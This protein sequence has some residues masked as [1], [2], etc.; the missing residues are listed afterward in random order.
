MPIQLQP[1]SLYASFD[2]FPSAKGAA[3]HIARMAE[4]L[5]RT[6]DGG[7][8]Y[9]LGGDDLPLYQREGNVEI[10]RYARS[11]PNFLE[12]TI[13]FADRLRLLLEE[14][15]DN[16]ALCHVRDPW[17][18]VPVLER[19]GRGYRT[20]YEVNGLPSIELP[21]TYPG[22]SART[23]AKIRAAEEFCWS[24]ADAIITPSVTIAE[25]LI[26]LGAPAGAITVIPNG[27][28][29]APPTPRPADAPPCYIIYFGALQRWQ[30]A[31]VMLHA[32]ARLADME[33]VHLVIC[34]ST[35]HRNVKIYRKLAERLGIDGRILWRF[36]LGR[37]ELR[38]WVAGAELSLAP[39]VECSRNLDQGCAPLKILESMACGVP[40]VASDLPA[41][42]ELIAD[43]IHGK[44][45]RADRPAD[46]ARAVRVLL[47]YPE[48]RREMGEEGR[49]RLADEFT[50]ERSTAKLAGLYRSV[51]TENGDRFAPQ[52]PPRIDDQS[53]EIHR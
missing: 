30:G 52:S 35:H 17:S 21:Y 20:V 45:V 42:R 43:G 7:V 31:D 5:F 4:T 27:A 15:G 41:T 39:L 32:F 26:R 24:R 14:H 6:M 9:T 53:M 29:P 47:E 10:L 36:A 18:G 3:T 33:D 8:L 11:V 12:R 13:G 25:N 50:W 23:L 37:E 48:R 1:R 19:S 16:L 44:L 49:R 38:G 46:L 51:I 34:S 2:R 22:L 40:V 28:D